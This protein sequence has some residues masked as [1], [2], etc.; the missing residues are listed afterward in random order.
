MPNP[1]VNLIDTEESNDDTK[2][3]FDEEQILRQ[4]STAQVIPPSRVDTPPSPRLD[5]LGEEKFDVDSPFGEH[6]DTLSTVDR[7]IDF[8]HTDIETDDP[9][10]DPRIFNVPLGNNDLISRSFDATVSNPLNFDDYFTLRIEN[11]IF[12]D[13]F[14]YLCT[15]DPTKSTPIIDEFTILVAPLPDSKVNSLREVERFDPFSP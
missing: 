11:T 7:G 2:A 3:I 15:L 1:P 14:E 10:P 9:V 12:D 4:Q 8:N 5:V 13:D 6:L